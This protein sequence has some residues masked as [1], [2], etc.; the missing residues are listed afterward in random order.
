MPAIV[1]SPGV[2]RSGT[3]RHDVCW[4]PDILATVCASVGVAQEANFPSDGIDIRP[5]LRGETLH[6][7]QPLFWQFPYG[8][9]LRDGV[10]MQSPGL[11]LRDGIW[12]R[13]CD[14]TFKKSDL[15]NLDIDPNKK[16]NMREIHP[17]VTDRM[18]KKM[19]ELP[20]SVNGPS[21]QSARFINPAMMG[22]KGASTPDE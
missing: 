13:H 7:G 3:V 20:T 17:E 2:T 18:L 12:K 1:R 9:G 19:R 11:A 10:R 21:A 4:T 22:V 8:A 14:P 5:A 16:W 6:R 15:Y